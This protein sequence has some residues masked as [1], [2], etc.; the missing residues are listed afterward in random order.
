MSQNLTRQR[1]QQR[2]SQRRRRATIL[3]MVW[4]GVVAISLAGVLI[5]ISR[6]AKVD[7][8]ALGTYEDIEQSVDTSLGAPGYA[9]G[10]RDAPVTLVDY[11]DFSCPH[12]ADLA[13]IVGR[14]I[15]EYVK[16]G[17]LRIVYMPVSFINPLSSPSASRAVVCAS[18]QGRGWEMIDRVWAVYSSSGTGG[19]TRGTLSRQAEELGL[20]ADEFNTCYDSD[21]TAEIIT[22]INSAANEQ[23]IDGTPTVI[24]NDQQVPY[25]GPDRMYDTLVDA[26]EAA[27]E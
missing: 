6:P 24:V 11:S 4:V 17:R 20:E 13:P 7:V 22:A 27:L 12:C 3:T 1:A 23:D 16:D 5:L 19:Y 25:T 9:I 26:I 8:D 10:D 21:E 2:R 15:D 18:D 14:L